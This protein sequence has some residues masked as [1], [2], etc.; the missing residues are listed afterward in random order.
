MVSDDP[1]VLSK[2]RDARLLGVEKDS[3]KRAL[4]QRS[5]SFQVNEQGWRYHMSNLMAA[6]GIV[7]LGRFEFLARKRVHLAETYLRLL[8]PFCGKKG[9]IVPV[10]SQLDECVPHIFPIRVKGMNYRD[11]LLQYM[12]QHG[13]ELGLHYQPNH[14]LSLYRN[15]RASHL[16]I[17]EKI[18]P[19]LLSLPP[20]LSEDDCD[21]IVKHLM[22]GL[23][24]FSV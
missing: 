14:L 9:I 3:S 20:D 7:Q 2:T 13:V 23:S 12:K 16:N 22:E 6:I 15:K 4:N 24:L 11:R 19:E 17:T 18:Y 8:Q 1:V 21:L 5:W 10:H